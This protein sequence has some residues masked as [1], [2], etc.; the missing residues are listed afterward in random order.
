MQNTG[1]AGAEMEARIAINFL[2]NRMTELA[3]RLGLHS[4][5]GKA[6][7]KA[8]GILAKAVPAGS[9]PQ[10][11][12]VAQMQRIMQSGRQNAANVAAMRG[13]GGPPGAGGSPAVPR[14]PAVPQMPG[15]AA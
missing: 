1:N 4:E 2:A 3:G 7:H 11:A 15:M 12:E 10:G 5:L 14:P 9:V 8:S 6:L 13:A